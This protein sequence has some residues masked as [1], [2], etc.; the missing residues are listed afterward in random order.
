[1]QPALFC[2]FSLRTFAE[3][4]D[5]MSKERKSGLSESFITGVIALVFLIIGYQ[6]ALLIHNAAV[7]KIAAD[8]D[9]PDTVYVY[10]GISGDLREDEQEERRVTVRKNAS[11]SPRAETVR[12][13]LPR[14]HVESFKFDPNTVTIDELCRL[15]FTVKQ[16]ESIDNYR[17]KGGRFRRKEDFKKSFVVS[18]SIYKR[19][20]KYID[21]PLVDLNRADS[22]D[23]DS[24]PGIGGWFAVKM[25]EHRKALRGYSYKRQLLDIYSFDQEKYDALSDL[26]VVSDEYITPYPL[27]SL[28][29]DS[30]KLHP[31]INDYQTA[32][33]I[34]LFR[35]NTPREDWNVEALRDAG[36]LNVNQYDRLS[37]CFIALP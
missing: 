10:Q 36:I 9:D 28:S 1:M 23:F 8:R 37:K 24:L 19:L 34:V 30:L 16:A 31:Y 7:V 17:S 22:A 2:S 27:W 4:L 29:A 35:V 6:T 18:D 3:S 13:N 12:N 11:H 26:I 20:E 14:I 15:G 5:V 32:E 21:I 25:I 33:A